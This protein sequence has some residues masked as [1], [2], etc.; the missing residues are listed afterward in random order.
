MKL[1]KFLKWEFWPFWLFYIPVYVKWLWLG[2]KA[3]SFV[4]FSAANPT[5]EMGGF[6]DYSKYAVLETVPH[7]Y[8]PL[9]FLL[10]G[11]TKNTD[12]LA[13][14]DENKISFPIILK[15]DKG[16][17]GYG[18]AKLDSEKEL[19]T[20][21]ENAVD[22]LILQ[23]YCDYPLEIGVMYHRLPDLTN[24]EIT[25]VVIKDFLSTEGDGI[26]TLL[27][28]FHKGKR[29]RYYLDLL[30]EKYGNELCS[31]PPKGKR[32]EL[33]SI[34]N[35]CRGTTFLDGNHLINENL[36]KVFDRISLQ[37][38]THFFG[39]FDLRVSSLH[40]LYKGEN[41]KIMEVNGANSE[42]AHIYDPNMSL[43]KAYKSMFSH[44]Q[45]LYAVSVGN[46]KNGVSYMPLSEAIRK[47]R[48]SLKEKN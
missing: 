15:P 44:W 22:E 12:I 38:K 23:E 14:M 7:E 43:F 31:I 28:L 39:R 24:G 45:N 18:V 19:N 13:I 30:E 5:M 29:T 36:T 21:L 33:E 6:I 20:Y 9:T 41:I 37:M 3:R 48:R 8:K 26:S 16:E 1:P 34:G 2:V 47:V 25:S 10:K 40:D 27:E 4:F 17:R 11:E 35:H 46:H 42:P 32:I